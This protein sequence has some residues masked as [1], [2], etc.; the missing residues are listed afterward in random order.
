MSKSKSAESHHDKLPPSPTP[1]PPNQNVTNVVSANWNR[2]DN[3][4]K[5]IL[6]KPASRLH[7]QATLTAARHTNS[8]QLQAD[9]QLAN[10]TRSFVGD[11]S[12]IPTSSC[13]THAPSSAQAIHH[14]WSRGQR[15]TPLLVA[16]VAASLGHPPSREGG[17]EVG[18]CWEDKP[19]GNTRKC[20]HH[21]L[22]SCLNILFIHTS[23]H[24][25]AT[26]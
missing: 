18:W 15:G 3:S 22:S 14:A 12:D 4:S 24:L 2:Q 21:T 9:V 16:D 7:L 8:S 13:P 26:S 23:L 19:S 11:R 6:K 25:P 10:D 20:S 5:G 17:V 1:P